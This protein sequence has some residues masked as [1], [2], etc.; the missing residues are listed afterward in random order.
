MKRV[1]EIDGEKFDTLEGF[2]EHIS[3][4]LIPDAYWGRNLDAFEDILRGGFGTPEEG[5]ILRWK[6]SNQSQDELGWEETVKYLEHNLTTCHPLNIEA[7]QQK[8]KLAR[9]EEGETIYQ[10]LVDIIRRHGL[11]G[12]RPE[13]GVELELL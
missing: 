7:V 8:L 13:D 4:I 3:Q 6:N 12:E 1:Y 9:K 10:V 5:F 2:F 11:N